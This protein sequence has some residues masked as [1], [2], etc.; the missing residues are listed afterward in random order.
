MHAFVSD[1]ATAGSFNNNNSNIV[2]TG[3]YSVSELLQQTKGEY[4]LKRLCTALYGILINIYMLIDFNI[5]L[6]Y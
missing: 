6:P 2:I 5:Y 4:Y 3:A 1:M